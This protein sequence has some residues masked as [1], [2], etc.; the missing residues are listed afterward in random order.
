MLTEQH[1]LGS[2]QISK[3]IS[4]NWAGWK[5]D[6]RLPA[7]STEGSLL[8]R[9]LVTSSH[10]VVEGKGGSERSFSKEHYPFVRVAHS[11]P[12]HLPE[13]PPPNAI[14]L[15]IGTSTYEYWVD[16]KHSDYSTFLY[17]SKNWDL[18]KIVIQKWWKGKKR[19]NNGTIP[20]EN[21]KQER[22]GKDP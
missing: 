10:L 16:I 8:G 14:I 15:G 20:W 12:K 7:Q 21:I 18:Q 13:D 9:R 4:H 19:I 11:L 3:V 1:R 6:I 22:K 2:L 5:S 17:Y